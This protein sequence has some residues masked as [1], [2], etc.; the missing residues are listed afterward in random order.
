MSHV[1]RRNSDNK[2]LR[3]VFDGAIHRSENFA[4][5][6]ARGVKQTLKIFNAHWKYFRNMI[7][8]F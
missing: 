3:T 5:F 6:P 4:F 8:V 1:Y 7:H 2:I